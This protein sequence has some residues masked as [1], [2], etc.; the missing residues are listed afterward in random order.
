[1]LLV[2][3]NPGRSRQL[4]TLVASAAILLSLSALP[5]CWPY[6]YEQDGMQHP[7]L[8]VATVFPRFSIQQAIRVASP[9]ASFVTALR[10]LGQNVDEAEARRFL[11][12]AGVAAGAGDIDLAAFLAVAARKMGARQSEARLAKCFDV[13]DD[14][15]SGSIPAEQLRQR[16]PFSSMENQQRAPFLAVRRGAHRLFD[17]MR[18]KPHAAAALPFDLHSPRRVSS[19]SCSLRS[20]I[21]NAVENRGEKHPAALAIIIFLC[22]EKC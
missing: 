18:S 9:R 8:F 21:R 4:S 22:S 10:S 3:G 2:M 19:L 15:C 16:A 14:A 7:F 17:K 6:T 11:E 13:F 5:I 20:P 12:D 1:M